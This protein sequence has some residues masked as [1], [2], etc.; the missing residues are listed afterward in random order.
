V[1]ATDDRD[2]LH[3]EDAKMLREC[4][5]IVTDRR[6]SGSPM[7]SSFISFFCGLKVG[8]TMYGL[9]VGVGVSGGEKNT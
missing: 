4:L 8:H 2:G 7:M 3:V 5:D 9:G 6:I 1:V